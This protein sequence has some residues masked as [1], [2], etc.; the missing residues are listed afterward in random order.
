LSE[1]AKTLHNVVCVQT[2]YCDVL[3]CFSLLTHSVRVSVECQL[4][5]V[6]GCIYHQHTYITNGTSAA[7]LVNQLF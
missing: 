2:A 5:S 1:S 4:T 6:W 7:A 3:L